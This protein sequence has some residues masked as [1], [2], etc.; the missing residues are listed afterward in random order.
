MQSSAEVNGP[1]PIQVIFPSHVLDS[2]KV[3]AGHNLLNLDAGGSHGDD[4]DLIV[5]FGKVGHIK[6]ALH[7]IASAAVSST[8]Q[9]LV[10]LLGRFQY[11]IA[12]HGLTN[13]LYA[14]IPPARFTGSPIYHSFLVPVVKVF[15]LG[16]TV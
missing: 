3:P 15:S 8:L 7:T 5:P 1:M 16:N 12:A 9:A 4:K 11:V 6:S 10:L 2:Q 14:D 13:S